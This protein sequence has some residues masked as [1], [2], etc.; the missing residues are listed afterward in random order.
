MKFGS[1]DKKKKHKPTSRKE[2]N[3]LPYFTASEMHV[4]ISLLRSVLQ[5]I[6]YHLLISSIFYFLEVYK[7]MVCLT[8]DDILDSVKYGVSQIL[9]KLSNFSSYNHLNRENKTI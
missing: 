1:Q 3:V 9:L 4:S 2:N 5:L 7:M 8:I 6:A